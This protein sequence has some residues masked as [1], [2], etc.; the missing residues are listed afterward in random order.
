MKQGS[1]LVGEKRYERFSVLHRFLHIL[2]MIGFIGLALTGLSLAFSSQSWARAFMWV[3][4]G[5][6]N[7]GSVHR[8]LAATT[9]S[10]L[11][12]HLIWFLYYKAVLHGS[13]TGPQSL[14]P[15]MQDVKDLLHHL[16]YFFGARKEAPRFNKFT[17]VEK[18]DYWAFF[19][20][21]NTMGLTGLFLWFP[22]TATR[23]F[24]GYFVNLAQVLHFYEAILAISIK[25]VI[26]SAVNHLRP[27]VYPANRSIFSGYVTE[28]EMMID[29][30]GQL[31]ALAGAEE[32]IEEEVPART[33]RLGVP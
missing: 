27:A 10:C 1:P 8:F 24:P 18:L 11:L 7:A 5:P 31:A 16:S 20:G 4:G 15:R 3:V 30:P 19:L 23:F 9:Y 33:R 26:H 28:K 32:E 21:M 6:E 22:E 13:W 12:A 17:Y 29:H 25:L 2:A 14:L